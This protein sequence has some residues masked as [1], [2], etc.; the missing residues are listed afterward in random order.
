MP[1]D[2]PILFLVFNRPETT[3]QVFQRIKEMQPAKLLIAADGPRERKEGEAEKCEEVRRLIIDGIDWPCQVETLFRYHN[4]GCGNAVSSAITWFFDNVTEG[5][6]LEDDT[7]PDPSFFPFCKTLLEKYRNDEQVKMISGN[8][9]QNGKWRGNG[10]YYFSAYSHNWG[11]ASWRRTWEEYDFTLDKLDETALENN[12]SFYFEDKKVKE[13]WMQTF[14]KL[15]NGI[16]NTWDVQMLFCTWAKRGLAILPNI[17][18]VSNIGFGESGTHNKNK[19][20]VQADIPLYSMD[21]IKHPTEKLLNKKADD[22]S[23]REYYAPAKKTLFSFFKRKKIGMF[24]SFLK[25]KEN[26]NE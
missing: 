8:N 6:I 1:F 20:D 25:H 23:F 13:Y 17:N 5:I 24:I 19:N 10:S 9:F 12:M 26:H 22:Y 2:V 15:R 4:L 14:N 3:R 16:L 7:L 18:L 21:E 11:W